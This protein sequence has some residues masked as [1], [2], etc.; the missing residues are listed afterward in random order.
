VPIDDLSSERALQRLQMEDLG[1]SPG[2][3]VPGIAV[4]AI[5]T[6][7]HGDLTQVADLFT[8]CQGAFESERSGYLLRCVID[9][10]KWLRDQVDSFTQKQTEYLSTDWVALLFDADKKARATRARSRIERIATILCLS[11]QIEPTPSADETEEMMRVAM[12]LSDREIDYLRE[13]IRI[14]GSMLETQDHIPRGSAHLTWEQGSW[15]SRVDPEIDSIFSKLES[16]GLVARLAPPNNLNIHADFQNRYVL[17]K[18]GSRFAH[19]VRQASA[20]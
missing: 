19:L 18:K 4:K 17:L 14:E 9:D 5:T 12:E 11:V 6:L 7:L 10:L 8:Q 13:L 3:A 20:S 16:Y 1:R 2:T 15:G